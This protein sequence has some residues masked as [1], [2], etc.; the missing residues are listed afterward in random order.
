M[1]RY[2]I[3]SLIPLILTIITFALAAPVLV[4]EKRRASEDVITMLEKRT[5]E[6][7]LDMLW[8]GLRYYEY[9]WGPRAR[10]R[11]P[12]GVHLQE[13]A[14]PQNEP[15]QNAAEAH[16]PDE[17]GP[18]PN[19]AEVH[20]PEAPV[21]P[22]NLAVHVPPLGPADSHHELMELD[23]DAPA[24]SESGHSDSAPSSPG[25]TKSEGWYTAPSSLGSDSDSDHWSTI[26]NAP[27]EASQSENLKAAD[28]YD[29]KGK[30]QV[31]RGISGTASGVDM[32]AAQMELR[33]AV[34]T[35]P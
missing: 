35:A 13:P 31:S 20:V 28:D 18:P 26:S 2:S 4:Q 15:A 30:G 10:N 17:P 9:V 33:S 5:R 22:P 12:A 27:S 21:P 25:S 34:N 32:N 19:P 7:D 24:G 8:D 1:R 16:V 23:D 3:V 6:Q 29:L 14:P 11:N